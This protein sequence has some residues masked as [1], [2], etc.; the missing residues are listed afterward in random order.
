M[1]PAPRRVVTANDA[2]GRSHFAHD[3][4]TP[5]RLD[6]GVGTFDQIWVDDPGDPD[7]GGKRDPV[8]AE[9][10][11][12]EPPVDG[13]RMVVV[14]FEP[15][16]SVTEAGRDDLRF[17]D[18]GAMEPDD[19][20]MHTTRTIDYGV[21]LSGEIVLELD[22]GEVRLRAG[23]TVVQRG[24]RHRWHNRGDERCTM[25]FVMVASPNFKT[26]R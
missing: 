12:L 5:G 6:L 2:A 22:D 25:A 10:V 1:S 3:G 17:D 7:A 18:D 4:E 21:V 9:K 8:A 14:T 13:S 23:D 20:G 24:T 16:S 15:E 11:H 26:A 19:P